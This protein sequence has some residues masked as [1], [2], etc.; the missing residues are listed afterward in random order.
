MRLTFEASQSLL[1]VEGG[2]EYDTPTMFLLLSKYTSKSSLN[3]DFC[4]SH[5]ITLLKYSMNIYQYRLIA[6]GLPLVLMTIL[7]GRSGFRNE[8]GS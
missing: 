4:S 6:L 1:M 2:V 7:V 3:P 8:T 5:Y